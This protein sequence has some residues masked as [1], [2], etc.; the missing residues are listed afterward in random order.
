[1]S[2]RSAIPPSARSPALLGLLREE[3]DDDLGDCLVGLEGVAHL[4]PH[5]AVGAGAD[6]MRDCAQGLPAAR[7]IL[8]VAAAHRARLEDFA[9]SFDHRDDEAL[10]CSKTHE[11][12]PLK[13]LETQKVTEEI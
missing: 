1:M 2:C 5:Q 12:P 11:W 9:D 7:L 3:H 13:G 6:Q 10:P 4:E 8:G